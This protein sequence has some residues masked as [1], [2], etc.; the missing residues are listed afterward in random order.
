MRQ[1]ENRV[2]ICDFSDFYLIIWRKCFVCIKIE[3]FVTS[4]FVVNLLVFLFLV[5]CCS[6]CKDVATLIQK[7]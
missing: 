1:E 7:S 2:G 4:E 5:Q 6:C 3:R